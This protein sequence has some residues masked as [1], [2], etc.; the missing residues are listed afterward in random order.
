MFGQLCVEMKKTNNASSLSSRLG[1]KRNQG[2]G[3]LENAHKG[4]HHSPYKGLQDI[5]RNLGCT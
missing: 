1:E 4:Q 3:S 2:K 5:S